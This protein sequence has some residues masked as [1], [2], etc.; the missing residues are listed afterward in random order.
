[1]GKKKVSEDNSFSVLNIV[2]VLGGRMLL[3]SRQGERRSP[4]PAPHKESGESAIHTMKSRGYKN[5][6]KTT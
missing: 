3:F 1:M 5:N 6:F 4:P 2:G